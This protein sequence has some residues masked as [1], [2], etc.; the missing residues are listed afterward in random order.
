MLQ[1]LKASDSN[2]TLVH[3]AGPAPSSGDCKGCIVLVHGIDGHHLKTWEAEPGQ[4][5]WY[6]KIADENPGIS[7]ITVALPYSHVRFLSGKEQ[8]LE[9]LSPNLIEALL[10]HQVLD[11]PTLFVCHSLGGLLVKRALTDAL[12]H[13][14]GNEFDIRRI[15]VRGVMFL[16]VPH[17]GS[18][19]AKTWFA[20]LLIALRSEASRDFKPGKRFIRDVHASFLR[21]I[22]RYQ[23][24][25][26]T[27]F[28][29]T[30]PLYFEY[31]KFAVGPVVRLIAKGVGPVVPPAYSAI[32][33]E[34][35]TGIELPSCHYTVAKLR[36]ERNKPAL[37]HIRAVSKDFVAKK[38]D[39]VLND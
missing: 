35:G 18:P 24:C 9:N 31:R 33:A 5:L 37:E 21:A 25:N 8:Y 22:G 2:V 15:N 14:R 13:A 34:V 39:L 17:H 4:E 16:G 32:P 36:L 7:V 26:V 28:H 20:W 11:S 29:E 19:L 10:D 6:E 1:R 38:P 27:S 30:R 3:L 12:S 23:L